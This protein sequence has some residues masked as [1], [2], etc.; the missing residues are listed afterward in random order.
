MKN[1]R[2]SFWG[3]LFKVKVHIGPTFNTAFPFRHMT[4][5]SNFKYD[6]TP[7]LMNYLIC[8]KFVSAPQLI[9]YFTCSSSRKVFFLSSWK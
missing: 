5:N 1:I 3:G 2:P 8:A 6:S 7:H 4:C 9:C